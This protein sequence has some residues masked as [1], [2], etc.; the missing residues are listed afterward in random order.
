[1]S[2]MGTKGRRKKH[3]AELKAQVAIAAIKGQHTTS[4]L[5]SMYGV[6]ATQI[7]GWKKQALEE[8]AQVFS[9]RRSSAVREQED[10]TAALYQQIG[11][12]NVKLQPKLT[13]Q[14]QV[15]MTHP[16]ALFLTH[17]C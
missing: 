15:K 4:E 13:H 8:L 1:M 12:L 3:T 11:Q 10:L 2:I 6:H 14:L 7:G 5:A 17:F 16:A 9:S